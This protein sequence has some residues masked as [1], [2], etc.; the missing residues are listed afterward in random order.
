MPEYII[1]DYLK[2]RYEVACIKASYAGMAIMAFIY[3]YGSAP[4]ENPEYQR[5]AK[6]AEDALT[7]IGWL[8]SRYGLEEN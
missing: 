8:E 3:M 5:A 2:N 6:Q 4:L 1:S 7:L